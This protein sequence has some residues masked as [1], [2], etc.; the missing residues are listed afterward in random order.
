MMF[1]FE[2]ISIPIFFFF[3]IL[4]VTVII[5]RTVTYMWLQLTTT[6]ARLSF[7]QVY[8]RLIRHTHYP[9]TP[10]PP[11]PGKRFASANT[12]RYAAHE[13]VWTRSGRDCTTYAQHE[14]APDVVRIGGAETNRE[15]SLKYFVGGGGEERAFY[16]PPPYL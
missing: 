9:A 16:Q 13:I 1:F 14:R 5:I 6:V 3:Y 7:V 8:I 10:P 2:L 12:Q 11:L 15:N 4:I